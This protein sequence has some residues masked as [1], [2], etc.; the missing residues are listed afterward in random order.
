VLK[1]R[2][3]FGDGAHAS[4]WD[5]SAA[6]AWYIWLACMYISAIRFHGRTWASMQTVVFLGRTPKCWVHSAGRCRSALLCWTQCLHTSRYPVRGAPGALSRRA[7]PHRGARRPA[8][9][10]ELRKSMVP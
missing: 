4:R 6:F 10:L 8:L 5:G 9:Q 7:R 3:G 2:S 1:F